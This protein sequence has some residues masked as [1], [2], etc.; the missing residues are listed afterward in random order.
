MYLKT[1]AY[2]T[3]S[4]KE[5]AKDTQKLNFEGK[6]I[7]EIHRQFRQKFSP[8]PIFSKSISKHMHIQP[9]PAKIH[10]NYIWKANLSKNSIDE[11]D[12]NLVLDQFSR[13]LAHNIGIYNLFSAKM[14]KNLSLKGNWIEEMHQRFLSTYHPRPIVSDSA[15]GSVRQEKAC[16]LTCVGNLQEICMTKSPEAFTSER[17]GNHNGENGRSRRAFGR[18]KHWAV[19]SA[20]ERGF[21]ARQRPVGKS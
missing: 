17:N 4:S 18:K 21:R 6:L 3:F 10:K 9:F 8:R 11:F 5:S 1:Q 13:T 20:T 2:T 12:R 15:L 14:F 16:V 7:E 19:P